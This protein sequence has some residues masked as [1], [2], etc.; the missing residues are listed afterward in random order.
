MDH[1]GKL[2]ED[3]AK[4]LAVFVTPHKQ[5][6]Q[7]FMGNAAAEHP[8]KTLKG[9]QASGEMTPQQKRMQSREQARAI[10]MA[11]KKHVKPLY[12]FSAKSFGSSPD[13]LTQR[14]SLPAQCLPQ[15]NEQGGQA[16]CLDGALLFASLL[17]NIQMEPLI[18]LI[19]GHA[20][21]GWRVWRGSAEYEFLETTMIRGDS[22]NDALSE[23]NRQ[24]REAIAR[25][26]DKRPFLDANGFMRVV[27]TAACHKED[28][29]PLS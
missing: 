1:E 4:Y 22:F 5:E 11:L 10:F 14:V 9:Y 24:Y 16:Y 15:G 29:F 23:G 8:E 26:D 2:V 12:V 28:I 19:P 17:E 3:L 6:I 25:G 20:F 27:D 18:V 13:T 7:N 21:V